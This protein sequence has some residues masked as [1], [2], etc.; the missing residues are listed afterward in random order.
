MSSLS[1]RS[2]RSSM[3]PSII[4]FDGLACRLVVVVIVAVWNL[5]SLLLMGW[6]VIVIVIVVVVVV[7]VIVVVWIPL[8]LLL[9]G[10]HIVV[11]N[12]VLIIPDVEPPVSR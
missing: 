5:A 3:D 11:V 1:S 7:V 9:I 4:I 10:R 6:N 12:S 8:S 2:N